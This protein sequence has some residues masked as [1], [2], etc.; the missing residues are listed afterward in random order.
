MEFSRAPMMRILTDGSHT[1]VID[2]TGKLW[3]FRISPAEFVC[4]FGKPGSTVPRRPSPLVPAS[5]PWG[6]PQ[7]SPR[8]LIFGLCL[9]SPLNKFRFF[10]SFNR[11][12]DCVQFVVSRLAQ[13]SVWEKPLKTPEK[14]RSWRRCICAE[15]CRFQ[16]SA[17]TDGRKPVR[18]VCGWERMATM[19]RNCGGYRWSSRSSRNGYAT[20][21]SKWSSSSRAGT[22]L[23]RVGPSNGSPSR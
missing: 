12:E 19:R 6:L 21:G 11:Y 20:K 23:E 2:E 5:R 15:D 8:A 4:G 7:G 14:S 16:S 22:V 9:S 3:F 10:F 18:R 13:G 17:T 1:C